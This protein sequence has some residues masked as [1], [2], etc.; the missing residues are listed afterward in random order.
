MAREQSEDLRRLLAGDIQP[1]VDRGLGDVHRLRAAARF[2]LWNTYETGPEDVY[3]LVGGDPEAYDDVC[4]AV[5]E[6]V[7]HWLGYTCVV[8]EF[9]AVLGDEPLVEWFRVA[10]WQ[11]EGYPSHIEAPFAAVDRRISY[12]VARATH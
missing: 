9:P 12:L 5:C 11:P 7:L 3:L 6:A 1:A 10:R 4:E 8:T 2:H